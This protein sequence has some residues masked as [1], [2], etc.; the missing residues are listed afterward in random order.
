MNSKSHAILIKNGSSANTFYSNKISS[1][2]KE[3]LIIS[4]DSTSKNNS[5]SNNQIISNGRAS[6]TTA[7]EPSVEGD[8]IKH[9]QIKKTSSK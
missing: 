1:T 5:F 2:N 7:A 8:T 3:G 9:P 6:T 4:Q